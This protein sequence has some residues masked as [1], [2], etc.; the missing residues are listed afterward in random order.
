VSE[1]DLETSATRR[2]SPL[3]NKKKCKF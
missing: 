1:F 3:G 2:L